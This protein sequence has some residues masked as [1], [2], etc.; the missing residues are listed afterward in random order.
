MNR[1]RDINFGSLISY[2]KDKRNNAL[3]DRVL[4]DQDS[5]KKYSRTTKNKRVDAFGWLADMRDT[6]LSSNQNTTSQD[7]HQIENTIK[8]NLNKSHNRLTKNLGGVY[9]KMVLDEIQKQKR[10]FAE[11]ALKKS[12]IPGQDVRG[13]A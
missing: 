7:K 8:K 11:V 1:R 3:S 2:Q 4:A 10:Q 12:F 5:A 13:H 6:P 9:N